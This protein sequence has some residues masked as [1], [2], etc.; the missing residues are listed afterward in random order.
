MIDKLVEDLRRLEVVL[1]ESSIRAVHLIPDVVSL[2]FA[3]E[4]YEHGIAVALLASSQVPRAANVCARSAFEAATDLM[5]LERKQDE[6]DHWGARAR[7]AEL[8]DHKRADELSRNVALSP[9]VGEDI[10]PF[11]ASA[12]VRREANE[13][14]RY[15]PGKGR[16]L[17]EALDAVQD[18]RAT[19][20]WHWSGTSRHKLLSKLDDRGD[21]ADMMRSWYNLLS[22]QAHS[23]PRIFTDFVDVNPSGAIQLRVTPQD[24][25]QRWRITRIGIGTARCSV[26]TATVLL[27][28]L[29][30]AQTDI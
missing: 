18:D 23:A 26:Q 14:E 8:L 7:V 20:K 4:V 13:W 19:R 28:N 5:F 2:G 10:A 11:D 22:I 6:Y 17:H 27:P 3:R 29:L 21:A 15:C 12:V 16:L 25:E 1:Q 9:A 24:E 30:E